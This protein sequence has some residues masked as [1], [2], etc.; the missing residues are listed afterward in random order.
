MKKNIVIVGGGI[1]GLALLHY[2][3]I[4]HYFDDE[5]SIQLLEK[6]SRPG[7]T[8][9]STRE[10]DYLFENGPN[11]FLDNKPNTL[12]FI[13]EIGT[14]EHLVRASGAAKIRFIAYQKALHALPASPKDF[15]SFKLLTPLDKLRI[16]MEPLL[17]RGKKLDESVYDFGRR[18]LGRKF[19]ELF[20]DPMV[21]GIYGG[22]AHKICLRAAFPRM[23]ELESKYRSLF[24]AMIRLKKKGGMPQG[25]LTSFTGGMAQLMDV[26]AKKYAD[27]IVCNTE[28]KTISRNGPQYIVYSQDTQYKADEL[29]MCTPAY[30]AADLLK[31]M[32]ASVSESLLQIPYAPMAVIGL[33]FANESFQCL[34]QG[35]GYLN[36]SSEK[37]KALGVL[38][39]SNIFPERAPEG[40]LLFRIMIGGARFPDIIKK[41]KEE[42]I[43]LALDE[44]QQHF[45][46]KASPKKVFYRM[47]PKAI[48]QYD[49]TYV[50][51]KAK[52]QDQLKQLPH[53]H[54]NANYWNGIS[55]NDCILDARNNSMA[56]S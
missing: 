18:R 43:N 40:H 9:Q 8:I 32:D 36:P 1:S 19:S 27:Q 26:A 11:G 7:G 48:P 4:R 44:I 54:L 6:G 21:S 38:F 5:V 12:K 49:Q 20:L 17:P 35:F 24:N 45:P 42:I 22:D 25:T 31:S 2:L 29:F 3:N 46:T 39:D 37:R 23:A 33:G 53:V 10:D 15:I 41:S 34:P 56:I 50:H 28:I 55:F 51:V 47:W 16:L 14:E 52:L 30:R 13:Q